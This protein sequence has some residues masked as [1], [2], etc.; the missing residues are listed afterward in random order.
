MRFTTRI[1][2]TRAVSAFVRRQECSGCRLSFDAKNAA[3][4]WV[5]RALWLGRLLIV[6][7]AVERPV[8]RIWT[9]VENRFQAA[10]NWIGVIVRS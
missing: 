10:R 9:E 1:G 4:F 5:S 6:R 8:F 7:L 2:V 3:S